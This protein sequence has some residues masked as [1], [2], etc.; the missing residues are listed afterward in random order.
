MF[1]RKLLINLET[2]Q[3]VAVCLAIVGVLLS[4]LGIVVLSEAK[5]NSS[6]AY[7]CEGG[8]CG[9]CSASQRWSTCCFT[10]AGERLTWADV[11]D[12]MPRTDVDDVL[13]RAHDRPEIARTGESRIDDELN[14][15]KRGSQS[16]EKSTAEPRARVVLLSD[17][18]DCR[19]LPKCIAIFGSAIC[20]PVPTV[21]HPPLPM[22]GWMRTVD[23]STSSPLTSPPIPPPRLHV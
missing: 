17:A 4:S 18:G 1:S 16:F 9:C 11:N 22:T 8:R 13:A 12:V 10:T 14:Q 7:L 3:R 2:L 5:P 19:G 6:Q 15:D 21:S 20:Q 23:A